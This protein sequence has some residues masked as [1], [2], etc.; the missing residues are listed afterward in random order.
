MTDILLIVA[1]MF[2]N[3]LFAGAEIAMLSIRKT[4]LR[5]FVRRRDRR[6]LA[7]KAL[8]DQPERFLATV[9]I[10][11][12]VVGTAAAAFGGAQLAKSM[13]PVFEL[14]GFGAYADSVAFGVVIAVMFSNAIDMA[15]FYDAGKVTDHRRQLNFQGLKSDVGVGIRFH[16]LVTTPVRLDFAYGNEGLKIVISGSAPF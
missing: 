2:A 6:A 11:I 16:G 8:R 9:Q 3:G 5:E 15:F 10:G 14:L 1:L 13:I 12:T 4:R 7:V